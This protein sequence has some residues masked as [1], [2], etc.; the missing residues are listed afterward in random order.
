MDGRRSY[1][2]WITGPMGCFIDG[3]IMYFLARQR[4]KNTMVY[5]S[6]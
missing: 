5:E 6:L 4:E 1:E 2:D 3:F